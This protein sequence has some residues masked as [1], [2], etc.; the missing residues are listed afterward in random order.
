MQVLIIHHKNGAPFISCVSKI[1]NVLIE[2]A[3]DLDV[4]I[5]IY[6]LIEYAKN[7]SKTTETLQ[8]FYRDEP[9][10]GLNNGINYCVVDSK[11]FDYKT[12]F[13]ESVTNANLIKQ[14]V[15]SVVPL[16]HLSEFQKTLDIPLINCEISLV[17][18]WSENCVLTSKSTR[19]GNYE[20]DP[21]VSR[22]DDPADATFKI[23]DTKLNAPVVT[24]ST[25]DDIKI[26]E[27]LNS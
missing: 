12:K 6:N 18:T 15:K 14:N 10:S 11:S 17:L 13:I 22:I 9:N 26:L 19:T 24:L 21:V 2:I 1:N 4:A 20:N 3:E 7:Y 16:K 5:S 8:N 25:E 23:T 27:Q